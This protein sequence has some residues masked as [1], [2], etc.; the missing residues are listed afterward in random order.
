MSTLCLISGIVLL[1]GAIIFCYRPVIP[2]A[3][4]SYAAM[5]TLSYGNH[6]PMLKD[7]LMFWGVATMIVLIINSS[8]TQSAHDNSGLG[9]ITIGALTGCVLGMLTFKGGII[10]GA[11]IGAMLGLTAFCR[12]PKGSHIKLPSKA[13]I[14]Q[15]AAKG[16]PIIVA[17]SIFGTTIDSLLHSLSIK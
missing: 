13:F 17:M 14:S 6:I 2:A 4:L 1:V 5:W 3:L 15:L 12:T 9:Y 8:A 10:I 11:A 16:L 7:T